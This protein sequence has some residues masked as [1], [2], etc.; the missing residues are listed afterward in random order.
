MIHKR[1][2]ELPF[3]ERPF[4]KCEQKGPESL[5]EEELL[6]VLFRHGSTKRRVTEI[7][8]SIIEL[9]ENYGGLAY[10]NRVPLQELTA[11]E[12]VGRVRA[13]QLICLG[14]LAKRISYKSTAQQA[15][16]IEAPEDIYRCFCQDMP[17]LEVE[18]ARVIYTDGRNNVLRKEL[19]TRGSANLS[20]VPIR[21]LLKN[22][23]RIG[24]VGIALVHNHPSGDPEP[25]FEDIQVTRRLKKACELMELTFLDHL[26]IAGDGYMSFKQKKLI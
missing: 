8:R 5:S 23:L 20:F 18:E 4:E 21:E 12:G 10:L 2:D 1:T 9:L 17:S 26:I 16:R 7:S 14:E 15:K 25:S 24:A 13:L 3:E 19:L 22:A 11:L 6:S